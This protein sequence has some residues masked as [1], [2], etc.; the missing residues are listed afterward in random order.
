MVKEF[1]ENAALQIP[2]SKAKRDTSPSEMRIREGQTNRLKSQHKI[3]NK[4]YK[5]N[6][7][8]TQLF[9]CDNEN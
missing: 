2:L 6:K 3:G 8:H 4:R 9:L 7:K 5:F 1:T